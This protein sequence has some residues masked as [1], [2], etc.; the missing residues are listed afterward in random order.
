MTTVVGYSRVSTEEQAVSGLGLAAQRQA[1][2]LEVERRG[3]TLVGIETDEGASAKSLKRE[4]L[5]RALNCVSRG[6]AAV[7]MVSKLD[8]LS[9]SVSDAAGLMER[10]AREGWKI[11]SLDLGVDTTTPAG[12]AMANVMVAFGQLERRLIGQRTKDA[13]AQK[14]R[15]GARLGRPQT[16]ASETRAWIIAQA[17]SGLG[18][19]EIARQLNNESVPT[20]HG[21]SKWHP[22]TVRKIVISESDHRLV[23][24]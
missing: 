19:T 9:R 20:A 23:G 11:A 17:N 1:I 13:L 16:L 21:G 12:E 2:E 15:E 14:R 18:W 7:L 6:E 3:W 5:A 24:S 22:A 10:A 8:R 4:G